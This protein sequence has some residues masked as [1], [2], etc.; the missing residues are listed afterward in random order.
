MGK[1]IF[2]LERETD[3]SKVKLYALNDLS[4]LFENVSWT[5]GLIAEVYDDGEYDAASDRLNHFLA[6]GGRA[7]YLLYDYKHFLVGLVYEETAE[8]F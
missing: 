4:K 7:V 8:N 6:N 3:W 2:K 1:Q 5:E